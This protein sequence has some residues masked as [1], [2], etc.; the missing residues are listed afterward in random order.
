M[1]SRDDLHPGAARRNTVRFRTSRER[2]ASR[3]PSFGL[4]EEPE[5]HARSPSARAPRARAGRGCLFPGAGAQDTCG[6]ERHQAMSVRRAQ[7]LTSSRSRAADHARDAG[8]VGSRSRLWRVRVGVARARSS[9]A[10]RARDGD[11]SSPAC[12]LSRRVA[13]PHGKRLMCRIERRDSYP[14]IINQ[15]STL[16]WTEVNLETRPWSVWSV[17]VDLVDARR[18]R[19][20]LVLPLGAGVG[21]ARWGRVRRAERLDRAVAAARGAVRGR[22]GRRGRLAIDKDVDE[23]QWSSRR[24][25]AS[26]GGRAGR[27]AEFHGTTP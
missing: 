23:R 19:C 2:S 1:R 9:R 10:G 17:L 26:T 24:P 11:S 8:P 22:R 20:H 25:R 13:R 16:L 7:A 6:R 15:R 5:K 4:V 21:C 27:A 12:C 18:A 3:A 14:M